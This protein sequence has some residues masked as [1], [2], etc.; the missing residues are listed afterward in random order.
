[1]GYSSYTNLCLN[2]IDNCTNTAAFL[3]CVL[4]RTVHWRTVSLPLVMLHVL[5][6]MMDP[7]PPI[8]NRGDRS[9]QSY[10]AK[11]HNNSGEIDMI[12]KE[13]MEDSEDEELVVGNS[14]SRSS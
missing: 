12:L 3:G 11:Y 8:P 7:T 13:D 9:A 6:C 1:M 2:F 4:L 5:C 10:T 14:A